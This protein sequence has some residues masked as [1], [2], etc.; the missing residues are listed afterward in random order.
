MPERVSGRLLTCDMG[1]PEQSSL[2]VWNTAQQQIGKQVARTTR[3][4]EV[5]RT[6]GGEHQ[7]ESFSTVWA[8][9]KPGVLRGGYETRRFP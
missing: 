5:K 6:V 9:R 8:Y 4:S 2:C 1:L 7:K 3:K